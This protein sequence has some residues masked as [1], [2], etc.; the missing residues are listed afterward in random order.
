MNPTNPSTNQSAAGARYFFGWFLDSDGIPIGRTHTRPA[1]GTST[2]GGAVRFRMPQSVSPTSRPSAS[3]LIVAG[4]DGFDQ[5]RYQFPADVTQINTVALAAEDLEAVG[6]ITNRQRQALAGGYIMNLGEILNPFDML[7][8]FWQWSRDYATG[9]LRWKPTIYPQATLRYR[10]GDA[11]QQRAARVFN[12][13]F[14]SQPRSYT[15]YGVTD[16]DADNVQAQHDL[17]SGEEFDYPFYVQ[18]FTGD[19][20]TPTFALDFKPISVATMSVYVLDENLG[21]YAPVEF[22]VSS[23]DTTAPYGFTLDSNP[24]SNKRGICIFQFQG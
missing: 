24:G 11:V 15:F 4:E 6:L 3:P 23:V 7:L 21:V 22:T 8:I 12:F 2:N 1:A 5:H 10:G 17:G 16:L 19:N 14:V 9:T 18:A 20:A 13:E